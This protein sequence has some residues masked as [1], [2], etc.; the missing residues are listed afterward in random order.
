MNQYY[1]QLLE[2]IQTKKAVLGVVGLGYVGLP[3]AVEMVKQGFTVIGIDVDPSKIEKIYQGESYIND[4][5]SEDLA[6]CVASGRFK[7]TTDYSMITVIDAL[8]ICVPTPLSEN[9]DPDTSYIKTV[10]DQLKLHMKKGI[11]ITLESTTYPGTTEELI[12][13]EIEA[14]GYEAGKDFF[15]CFSPERIDPSNT[16]FNT[17]NTPKVIGG[18]TKACL[19]LG[20]ALYSRYVEKIVPVSTTKVAEMSKLLE[21]TFRSVNIAFINEMAM[22]CDRMGINI[23]EVIDAAATK[24]FGFMPF[25]PGPGIGGHCIPLDPMY[26][27]WKAKGFRFY[28]KF[29]E[30]AQSTNDNMPYYVINKTSTILNEYA[31]S[32]KKSSVLLLGMAYKSDIS[33]VRESP[34]LEVYDLFKENGAN[35][36]YYDPHAVSFRDKQGETVHSIAYDMKQFN[37]YDCIVL[38]TNHS[39]LDYGEIAALG[40]PIL[41]TR[42]AFRNYDLAHIYKIGHSVQHVDEPNIALIV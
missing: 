12:Q 16:R 21:N 23:W 40:V 11:L 26:L 19:E 38:I 17:F 29:I 15:L 3:L 39:G 37:K 33:D 7:P 4:I 25:Y 24:P 5:S 30:L 1:S 42:N 20:T 13:D 35:V 36:D 31:K 34:G 41:D 22:M 32:I 18:T 2:A 9:Q 10:V 6:A 28:S 27:S 14:I 8:S